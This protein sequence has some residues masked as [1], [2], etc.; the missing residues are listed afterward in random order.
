[1]SE[2]PII[3]VESLTKRYRRFTK[4][5][6][7][8]VSFLGLPIP[9]RTHD[10]FTALS[11]LS[12][13]VNRGERLAL[14]G[15]NGAGK[16]TLLRLVAG[17]L[18]PSSGRVVVAGTVQALMEIGADF[19]M[20]L[21]GRENVMNILGLAALDRS[22][23][24]RRYAEVVDFAELEDFMERPVREYSAGMYARLA[25]A[26]ATAVEPE[27]LIIDEVLGAGDAHFMHKS[28]DRMKDLTTQ[29]ATILFVSHDM[30]AAQMLCDRAIWLDQGKIMADGPMLEVSKAYLRFMRDKDE[31]RMKLRAIGLSRASAASV[32][33]TATV[34]RLVGPDEKPPHKPLFVSRIAV[35]LGAFER[36]HLDP[37]GTEGVDGLRLML[38]PR[39]L[40]WGKATR[41]KSRSARPFGD[42][43]GDYRHAPWSVDAAL[44]KSGQAWVE[45]D[46]LP[47]PSDPVFVE[48]F[49]QAAQAYV[50]LGELPA[51]QPQDWVTARFAIAPPSEDRGPTTAIPQRRNELDHYGSGEAQI[52][53]FVI[54]DTERAER[55][56]LISGET[57]EIRI[58]YQALQPV[59]RPAVVVAIYRAADG[60]CA[61]QLIS[62]LDGL[63][64]ERL[65]G[66][67]EVRITLSPLRLGKGEYV[68]SAALFERLDLSDPRE[69]QAYHVIDRALPF[70][71]LAPA[72]LNIDLGAFQ[73]PARWHH[74]ANRNA[75]PRHD[76]E[77]SAP[78]VASSEL[79]QRA[80]VWQQAIS[81][82]Q[83]RLANSLQGLVPDGVRTVLDFGCG[84]GKVTGPLQSEGRTLLG[85][86]NA[87]TALELCSFP[88]VQADLR[89]LPIRAR[90]VDMA[91]TTDVF[92]HL[93]D[94]LEAQAREALFGSADRFAA[95][96]VPFR[97]NLLD[98]TARCGH[99]GRPYHLNWHQR[100]YGLDSLLRPTVAGWRP[101]AAVL[102]GEPWSLGTPLEVLW[103][104]LAQ[105]EWA[106]WEQAVCPACGKTGKAAATPSELPEP[107]RN[108]LAGAFYGDPDR[109]LRTR[110]HSEVL[111]LFGRD[112]VVDLDKEREALQR[113]LP[114]PAL[115]ERRP[116]QTATLPGRLDTLAENM[117]SL[118]VA[119]TAL[120]GFDGR[121]V[122]QFPLWSQATEI[123]I[124]LGEALADRLTASL[125]D[126]DGEVT[127]ASFEP[128]AAGTTL[129]IPL[130]R[131]L[132]AGFHG[133]LLW[134]DRDLPSAEI[135]L[136]R[137]AP[138]MLWVEPGGQGPAYLRA[139]VADMPLFV[140]VPHADW[141]GPDQLDP[142][143]PN[144]MLALDQVQ[145]L[146]A[147]LAVKP[148]GDRLAAFLSQI[149][150]LVPRDAG[151]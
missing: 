82:G 114:T 95:V 89:R 40:N 113:R 69:P 74:E 150:S 58:G 83:Q 104:R 42:F 38:D 115:A 139:E 145:H 151:R 121:I 135:Q 116:V 63:T 103:R 48:L 13:S 119:A 52:T 126:R 110:N 138:L 47:S 84:D 143:M 26:V 5:V 4:P 8:A 87:A 94:G 80:S 24:H 106:D 1:M 96:A 25:F 20:D 128:S 100:A 64:L 85:L 16:T 77:P 55:H 127:V 131:P 120:R 117:P 91:V 35:G 73:H 27:I 147:G 44:A 134:L 54:G 65:E 102:T 10:A 122:I 49:D 148:E 62:N 112:A 124:R 98:G 71:V 60:V 59:E 36:A 81:L 141:Q 30:S 90:S 39:T 21:T 78:A 136:G 57:A 56:T 118:P 33:D 66:E 51:G 123:T 23:L 46:Y 29:G 72:G 146:A 97:E 105:E 109:H 133:V 45:L 15:A 32:D 101:I 92:E 70:Q 149:D 108:A 50:R 22:A 31:V 99:C 34:M 76:H 12:F 132:N 28:L 43:G 67:G 68:A 144:P 142:A 19:H 14:I 130:P 6:W 18:R 17:L 41:V 137:A 61:T 125:I 111:V 86:D 9:P 2:Q 79:Y 7:Q 93:D 37:A 107:V 129:S 11:D 53:R 140:E 75:A 88:C 3:V